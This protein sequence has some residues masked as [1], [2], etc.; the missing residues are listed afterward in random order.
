MSP[1]ISFLKEAGDYNQE[2]QIR[3]ELEK[4]QE[5]IEPLGCAL[6][7]LGHLNKRSGGDQTAIERVMGTV[8]FVNFVRSLLI[9]AWDAEEDCPRLIHAAINLTKRDDDLLVELVNKNE[10]GD[11]NDRGPYVRSTCTRLTETLMPTRRSIA[12]QG[13]RSRTATTTPT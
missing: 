2:K 7:G 3:P 4:L 5:V 9:V 10:L 8:A 1:L 11:G 6:L 12:R 13:P